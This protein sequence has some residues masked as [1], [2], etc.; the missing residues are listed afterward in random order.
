LAL[1]IQGDKNSNDFALSL[2]T[3]KVQ[4]DSIA[5][6]TSVSLEAIKASRFS[7]LTGI[8]QSFAA[9]PAKS[10][11]DFHSLYGSVTDNAGN[12]INLNLNSVLI[13]AGNKNASKAIT[14]ISALQV[15]QEQF[16][17]ATAIQ[18]T[19]RNGNNAN[20]SAISGN[21]GYS[22]LGPPSMLPTLAGIGAGSGT[23]RNV[24]GNFGRAVDGGSKRLANL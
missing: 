20:Q 22:P 15:Q 5:M 13:D 7:L 16:I 2:A 21:A 11:N 14:N 23:S 3:L 24:P 6:Q 8:A 1:Q 19:P 10:G 12:I 9:I 18:Q 17:K 4:A